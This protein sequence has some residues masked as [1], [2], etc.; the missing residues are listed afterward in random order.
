MNTRTA[1]IALQII[2]TVGLFALAA[3]SGQDGAVGPKGDKGDTGSAGEA[4]ANAEAGAQGD[5]GTPV[6]AKP[7]RLVDDRIDGWTPANRA[8]L[9]KLITDKGITS[10]TFDPKNR[11]VAVFDWDNTVLKNDIGDATFFWMLRHDK[12]RQPAGKDWGMSSATLTTAAKAAMN[13]ACDGLAAAGDP[14]PTSTDTACADAIYYAYDQGTTPPSAGS[15]PAWSPEKTLTTDNPYAWAGQVQQGYTPQEI[16]DFARAAYIEGATAPIGTTQTVGS[17]SGLNGYV[18][19]YDQIADLI[20]AM[21]ENGFDVWVVSASPEW[22]VAAI[23]IEAG[24]PENH[25]VGIRY[26]LS[27]GK[28]TRD[29]QGCGTIA[30]AANTIITFD[31]GKRC[32]INKTIF[33]ELPASQMPTNP[34]L[35]K[36]PTFVAGDSDTDIAMLKDATELKLV[37][38]RNKIQTMCNALANYQGKWIWNPMFISPKVKKPTPYACSTAKDAAG[39]TIVNE[40]GQAM[41]DQ[42]EP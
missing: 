37:I 5:A 30:D 24:V 28:Q 11:P 1:R 38:N 6:P 20:G 7:T 22:V 29:M 23:S 31:E 40:A 2:G 13:A 35:T 17:V 26:L 15:V 27:N 41:T 16:H 32:F 19:I 21:Q 9:N 14:L 33:H 18:R 12:I 39:N 25:V 4:G 34:V 42:T 36:R 3:C 8:R 10:S